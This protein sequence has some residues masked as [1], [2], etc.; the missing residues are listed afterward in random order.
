[1]Q[2][3]QKT[4]S[5][6]KFILLG[7]TALSS[8]G[9]MKVFKGLKKKK[10]ETVKMLSQD[11]KLVEIPQTLLSKASARKISDKELQHWVKNK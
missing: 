6:K 3:V 8:L 2:E 4:N 1:M 5:R 9:M 10:P 7:V 11:G